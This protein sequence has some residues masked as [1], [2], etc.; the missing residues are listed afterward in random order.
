MILSE[1]LI[2][3]LFFN[4][5]IGLQLCFRLLALPIL[6]WCCVSTFVSAITN[7]LG[8]YDA[9]SAVIANM[10]IWGV[11][12]LLGRMY[13]GSVEGLRE[14]AIGLMIGALAYVP[15]CLYEV[16]MSPQLHAKIYGF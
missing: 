14:L 13:F 11:P 8:F 4:V 1:V 7:G 5:V 15:F 2:W 10:L 12:Y 9:L 6:V 3:S 16:R